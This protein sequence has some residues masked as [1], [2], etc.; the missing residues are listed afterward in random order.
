MGAQLE[1]DLRRGEAAVSFQVNLCG[2]DGDEFFG[3]HALHGRRSVGDALARG[4][5]GVAEPRAAKRV[6]S[7]TSVSATG[8][9]RPG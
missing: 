1:V 5:R 4:L 8:G 9:E 3:A 6:V 2:A 7:L